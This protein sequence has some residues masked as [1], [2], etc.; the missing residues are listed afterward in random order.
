MKQIAEIDKDVLPDAD[1]AVFFEIN[2]DDWLELLKARSRPADHDKDF[3]KNF[4]TQKFL[5]EATQKLC[6]EKG[7]ELIIFPQDN[8][9]A[10]GA[11]LKLKGLLKDKISEKS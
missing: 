5:L 8:S 6:Q 4:E 10:Q 9:S 11:S 2:Y 3:M 1:I 7:I